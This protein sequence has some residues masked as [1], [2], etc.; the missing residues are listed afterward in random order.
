M[1]MGS[2]NEGRGEVGEGIAEGED[3][4]QTYAEGE[5]QSRE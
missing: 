3:V 2:W 1:I 4:E 5:M